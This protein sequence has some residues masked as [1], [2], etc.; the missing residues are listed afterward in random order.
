[1]YNARGIMPIHSYVNVIRLSL[2]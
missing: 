2:R 1:V